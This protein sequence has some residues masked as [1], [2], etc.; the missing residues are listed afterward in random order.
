MKPQSR[1]TW[2]AVKNEPAFL[3]WYA[4]T[5][6]RLHLSADP[7]DARHGYDYRSYWLALRRGTAAKITRD[8]IFP[9]EFRRVMRYGYEADDAAACIAPGCGRAL[10]C[11]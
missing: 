1:S 4:K 10:V 11:R 9:D 5:A 3:R 2:D 7:D 6:K 8:G